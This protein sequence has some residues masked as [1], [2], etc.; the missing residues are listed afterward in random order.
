MSSQAIAA[1]AP[2]RRER[3]LLA[4]AWLM[5]GA[6]LVSGVLTY[7]FHILAARALGP[8]AYGRIAVLWAALFLA[9]VVLCRPLEQT[10]SRSLADRLER[11]EETAT[12]LRAVAM[13][14]ATVLVATG[15][16]AAVG[17]GAVRERLFGGDNLL[18]AMLVVGLAIYV[19][20]YVV[21]GL[22]AGVGWFPGYGVAL[23]ADT[24]TRLALALPLVAVASQRLA[25]VAVAGAG[26]AGVVAPLVAA[27]GRLKMRRTGT[28]GARFRPGAALAFAAPASVVAAADQLFVNGGPLLV[29]IAG[30]PGAS[31]AAGVVFAATML[32]RVPVFLF[33]GLAASLL[34]NLTRLHA[35]EGA[36]AAVTQRAA[37]RVAAWLLA[38]G[39]VILAGAALAGPEALRAVYGEGFE[40]T[41]SELV[42]LAAG[43]GCYLAAG[44]LS[45]ALLA[46]GRATRAA[47][48][49]SVSASLFIGLY[50]TLPGTHLL[51]IGAGFAGAATC[52]LALLA[53]A[54]FVR[55]GRR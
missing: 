49:W 1:S 40:A 4:G 16:A 15:V 30:E 29:V 32:V 54:L 7:A 36:D 43:V 19:V 12:V 35:V 27:R 6:L 24:G 37:V 20:A 33:Q 26:A 42:L 11:G 41:R 9:A 53:V 22:V 55:A 51:R 17:W 34:P 2:T 50:A 45:Q 13:L 21:R 5:S 48:A 38:V 46:L 25:A 44:T 18:T 52:A 39:G 28:A 31:A 23:L 8:D 10:T 47:V 14:A 3:S